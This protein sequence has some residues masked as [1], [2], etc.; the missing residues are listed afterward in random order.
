VAVALTPSCA[1]L[2]DL[3]DPPPLADSDDDARG[4]SDDGRFSTSRE[5][6]AAVDGGSHNPTAKTLSANL[7]EQL[8]C[9]VDFSQ[10]QVSFVRSSAAHV[11][12]DCFACIAEDCCDEMLGCGDDPSCVESAECLRTC[13]EATCVLQCLS[14]TDNP[15]TQAFMSCNLTQCITECLPTGDC[16]K[17]GNEC[18][19]QVDDPLVRDGCYNIAQRGDKEACTQ[20]LD[21][22]ADECAVPGDAGAN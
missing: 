18:C 12:P 15:A 17:L 6:D 4:S 8:E 14:Q 5:K 9:A 3:G 2:I 16:A 11:H 1:T 20:G 21:T 7:A 10:D 22:F 13:F 19:G